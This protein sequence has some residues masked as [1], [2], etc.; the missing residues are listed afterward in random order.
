[1]A[2]L[3]DTFT[4]SKR[5]LSVQQGNINT[6]AHNIANAS[7]VGYS[8][9]RAVVETTRPFGGN[10]KWD[11]CSAGQVGTG[12]QITTIQRI[13][14][15]FIDYQYRDANSILG[16]SQVKSEFLSKIED[17][18]GET[19]DTG[20]QGLMSE[21]YKSL[22]SLTSSSDKTDVK[23]VVLQN[24]LALTDAINYTYNQLEKQLGNA[25]DLLGDNVSEINGY[26]DQINELNKQIARVTTM[27]QSP[28][29][30]MDSRDALLDE[31]SSKFGF[32]IDK[33]SLNAIDINSDEYDNLKLVN[34]NPNDLD[35][36]RFSTVKSADV[37][38]NKDGTYSL[39]IEYYKLGDTNSQPVSITLSG[40]K[41]TLNSLKDELT[42]CRVLITDKDGNFKVNG[43][44]VEPGTTFA[45]TDANLNDFKKNIFKT[46]EHEAGVNNVPISNDKIKGEI[47][48]NQSVQATIK[49]Y[50]NDLDKLAAGVAYAMNAVQTGSL[51]GTNTVSDTLIFVA[52]GTKSDDKITA[53]NI[54]I[55]KDILDN[56]SL[57]NCKPANES[58]DGA[59]DR[60]IAMATLNTLKFNFSNV[61]GD[62]STWTRESFLNAAGVSFSNTS[63]NP[64]ENI[65]LSGD[66]SGSTMV[67]HYAGIISKLGSASKAAS[68]TVT[69]QET[70]LQGLENQRMSESGVSLDEEMTDIITFQH[71]YQANAKM[72]STIDELLDVVIN[73]LKR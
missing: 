18:L 51:D 67:S 55:N 3:F 53:K 35:Y 65:N 42:T 61:S 5:G 22:Q 63:G 9:Q 24:A 57:L 60:A 1:M 50:M 49:G 46:Y 2:G 7:T 44:K 64:E 31:L 19:S 34:A 48:G 41:D 59:N 8:R 38:E 17:I 56:P 71:A 29:D 11:N 43:T 36:N 30:L 23:S 69:N 37:V 39:N 32:N 6:T 33:Q 12:A 25:Q 68:N 47:A 45:I 40:D 20:I 73:G 52:S 28:N 72:I 14:N 15:E 66:S 54:T 16:N 26:L 70:V 21:F 10:G 62:S 13:R 4:I 27:G 58:G